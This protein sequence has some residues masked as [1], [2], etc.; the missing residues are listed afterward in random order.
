MKV[1]VLTYSTYQKY[2]DM[3]VK[4]SEINDI[5]K[6]KQLRK[7]IKAEYKKVKYHEPTNNTSER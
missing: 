6:S 1:K 7:L 5:S 4:I 2:E 3:L